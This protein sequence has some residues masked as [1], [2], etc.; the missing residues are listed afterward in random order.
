MAEPTGTE[1]YELA[2]V[3]L[4]V[5]Q[6]WVYWNIFDE[7]REKLEDMAK[8]L[9]D[10]A[11]EEVEK[12]KKY[13]DLD[14]DYRRLYDKYANPEDAAL[15]AY[16]VCETDILRSKGSAFRVFG[17][18]TRTARLTNYGYT[19]LAMVRHVGRHA[20]SIVSASANARAA[21][22]HNEHKRRNDDLLNRWRMRISVPVEREGNHV[23][24]RPVTQSYQQTFARAGQ[25][26]NSA[27]VAF[28]NA[29]YQFLR[30]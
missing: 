4:A 28:G 15:N 2:G 11:E 18:L 1:F 26:F 25:G 19:P 10:F 12:Y 7:Y 14:T 16:N 17:E 3:A 24:F 27:G 13:R 6:M 5:A 29:L 9:S 21:T 23:D 30:N 8:M 20:A 22:H